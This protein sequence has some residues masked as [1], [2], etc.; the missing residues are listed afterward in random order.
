MKIGVIGW[1]LPPA[2]SGGLGIHTINIFSI[3]NRMASI[4]LYVPDVPGLNEKYPFKVHKVGLNYMAKNHEHTDG[5]NKK[6]ESYYNGNLKFEDKI[7]IYNKNVIK[8]VDPEVDAIHC[9]DWITFR[10]GIKLKKKYGIP[11]VATVHSTEIDRSGNFFPQKHIMDIEREGMEIADKI[12]AVSDYTKKI[13]VNNYGIADKKIE[14]IYNGL[15]PNFIGMEPKDY[16]L[17]KSVL[18]FGRVTTQKGPYFFLEAAKKTISKMPGIKFIIVGTGDLI[19]QMKKDAE[20][21]GIVKNVVFTGFVHLQEKLYYYRNSDIFVLPAVS[22]PFGMSVIEA[23]STGT[24]AIISNTTGVGESLRNVFK[25]DFW[26]TDYISEY[27]IGILKYRGLR[28]T[29]GINGQIEAKGFTWDKS[30][31]KTMEVYNSIV[32]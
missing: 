21:F 8:A 22:E 14:V 32:G 19:N 7:R 29:M 10:A 30:A 1:E 16:G 23:M 26:D 24:P 11:M 6:M 3:L 15:D 28:E 13:I 18:Y 25:C 27:I 20:N 17:Q 12:I 2:F 31:I 5:H 9:H 4:T